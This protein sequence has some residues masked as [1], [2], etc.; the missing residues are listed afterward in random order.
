MRCLLLGSEGFL[1]KALQVK[2]NTIPHM[3]IV[4]YD[5]TL[6]LDILDDYQLVK[7]MMDVDVV[8]HLAGETGVPR[9]WFDPYIYYQNN[10]LGSAH[11][12]RRAREL[13]KKVIYASTGEVYVENS[14]YAASKKG[15]ESA[16]LSELHK[17]ADIVFLRILNPFGPG[18][19]EYYIIPKFL[20]LAQRGEPI[21][22]HGTGEQRKDYIYVDDITE[23]FWRARELPAGAISDLGIRETQ[24]IKEIAEKIIELTNSKSE[25]VYVDSPRLGEK[26]TLE[27]N[28]EQLFSIG[29]IPNYNFDE[30]LRRTMEVQNV[31]V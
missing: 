8:F 25:I 17:G 5:L 6:G 29:W 21:T 28:M 22:I 20:K 12:F 16:G 7:H 10:T 27:G 11:V 15:A 2:L 19:P 1:G 3:E 13:G 4:K 18:Q 30:G 9:S 24:S 31:Q 26:S 14:P 23:A